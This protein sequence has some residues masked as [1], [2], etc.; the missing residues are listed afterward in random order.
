MRSDSRGHV[1]C[2]CGTICVWLQASKTKTLYDV[3]AEVPGGT[4]QEASGKV[5]LFMM[6]GWTQ[7]VLGGIEFRVQ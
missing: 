6:V 2:A 3:D 5:I 4:V 7:E 1:G